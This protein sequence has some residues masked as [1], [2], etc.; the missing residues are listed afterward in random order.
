[1]VAATGCGPLPDWT[2]AKRSPAQERLA[3]FRPPRMLGGF[4]LQ[5]TVSKHAAVTSAGKTS[6]HS[7]KASQLR[8]RLQARKISANP[9][10]HRVADIDPP[11]IGL[12]S[13]INSC[14]TAISGIVLWSSS[15][16]A[17]AI[18]LRP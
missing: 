1:M 15:S 9:V 16:L 5:T 11:F 3:T 10:E 12:D 17:L 13:W 2:A 6:P 7:P 8:R 14:C 18:T 4:G